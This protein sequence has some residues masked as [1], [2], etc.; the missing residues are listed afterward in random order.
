[1]VAVKEFNLSYHNPETI[2]FRKNPHYGGLGPKSRAP[3]LV[4]EGQPETGIA[5][6]DE[7]VFFSFGRNLTQAFCRS[8][9]QSRR[10]RP[11]TAMGTAE[12]YS[13]VGRLPRVE[14]L[15]ALNVLGLDDPAAGREL[16]RQHGH[17]G[18]H[19]DNLRRAAGAFV[20]DGGVLEAFFQ[21]SFGS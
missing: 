11:N 6:Q 14:C 7:I 2:M 13:E 9:G 18:K 4:D 17:T 3:P 19:L 10:D 1:M 8:R 20:W 15:Y 21:V 16:R 12:T 5:A